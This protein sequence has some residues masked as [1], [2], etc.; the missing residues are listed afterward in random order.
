M[1]CSV[2]PV[3]A[4]IRSALNDSPRSF[5]KPLT[6]TGG[7][8]QSERATGLSE[9]GP[10]P[11]PIGSGRSIMRRRPKILAALAA[12]ALPMAVSGVSSAE[13]P[14]APV[15]A[16]QAGPDALAAA[17]KA[18]SAQYG[19]PESVLLAVSYAQSRWDDHEGKSST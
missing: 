13:P 11:P 7:A 4:A 1:T 19:V 5:R 12:V 6:S 18:A 8:T 15:T 2:F 9:T 10:G 3:D 17:F 16:E 14:V